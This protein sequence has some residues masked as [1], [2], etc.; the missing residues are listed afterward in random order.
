MQCLVKGYT[1]SQRSFSN[2]ND[3]ILLY[4]PRNVWM[5]HPWHF[6]RPGWMGDGATWS[7]G[8]YPYSWQLVLNALQGLFQPFYD[9]IAPSI[10]HV[11]YYEESFC[12]LCR[13]CVRTGKLSFSFLSSQ[14]MS[15]SPLVIF[16]VLLWT[17]SN[18]SLS[19]FTCE[20]HNRSTIW[21]ML[22]RVRQSLIFCLYKM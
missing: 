5:P 12:Y 7:S 15:S 3:S 21:Q 13:H 8:K 11:A 4:Y 6:S 19:S 1:W 2:L 22:I 14:G 9:S 16:M 20:S 10:L 18:L 17:F